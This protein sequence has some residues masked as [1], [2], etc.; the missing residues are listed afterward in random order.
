MLFSWWAKPKVLFRAE[1]TVDINNAMFINVVFD[2]PKSTEM[3]IR[4]NKAMQL[5]CQASRNGKI[6]PFL[7]SAIGIECQRKGTQY[8]MNGLLGVLNAHNHTH[9]VSDLDDIH[10]LNVLKE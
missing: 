6:A 7:E 2:K 1:I 8:I 10:P 4:L 3:N 5:I 9:S